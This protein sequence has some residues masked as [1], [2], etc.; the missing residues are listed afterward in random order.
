MTTQLHKRIFKAIALQ[1]DESALNRET[2]IKRVQA[3]L[4]RA[5]RAIDCTEVGCN[6]E[7]R[8][9]IAQV[10]DE[11]TA[12]GLIAES[13]KGYYLLSDSPVILRSEACAREILTLLSETPRSK[14]EIRQA[15]AGRFGTD[16]TLTRRDDDTLHGMLAKL[17]RRMIDSRIIELVGDKYSILPD[18]IADVGDMQ[19]MLELKEDFLTRLH[20]AGGEFFEHYYMT[21]LGKYMKKHGRNVLKNEVNGGSADGGIDGIMVTED[22]LGFR[23]TVMVQMKNRRQHTTETVIRGFWG[24]VCAFGGTRGIFATTSYFHESATAFLSGIDSCVGTDGA[25]I[26]AMACECRYGIKHSKDGKYYIDHLVL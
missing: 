6:T 16:K 3:N 13:K 8:G 24:A 2:L 20:A 25:K 19:A 12:D 9:K 11:M 17:L 10:I 7:L 4:A 21:L 5:D 14:S 15:L 22:S 26:F 23:E 1:L 18:K